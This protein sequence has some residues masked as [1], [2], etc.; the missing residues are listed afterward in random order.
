MAEEIKKI[1]EELDKKEKEIARYPGSTFIKVRCK[2]CG[3]EIITFSH[4]SIRVHCPGC[5]EI[6]VEPT[7]GKAKIKG[8]IL[9]EYYF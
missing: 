2:N 8:E 4:A 6:L 3:H 7:G 5:N 1:L 9:E